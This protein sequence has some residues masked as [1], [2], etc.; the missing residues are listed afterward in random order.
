MDVGD[1]NVPEYLAGYDPE[2]VTGVKDYTYSGPIGKSVDYKAY[3]KLLEDR[4]EQIKQTEDAY[5]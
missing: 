2:I 1:P 4:R 3:K 5:A